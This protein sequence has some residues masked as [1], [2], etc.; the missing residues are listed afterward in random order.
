MSQE[1]TD[2]WAD[3]TCADSPCDNGGDCH[4]LD[5]TDIDQDQ[6]E[7]FICRCPAHCSGIICQVCDNDPSTLIDGTPDQTTSAGCGMHQL[8]L[9][10]YMT[11]SGGDGW[12]NNHIV[13]HNQRAEA[14][15]NVL[16]ATVPRQSDSSV[17]SFCYTRS[18]CY[19]VTAGGGR[20][21]DEISWEIKFPNGTSLLHGGAPF[22]GQIGECVCDEV[23]MTVEM[24]DIGPQAGDGWNDNKLSISAR[25]QSSSTDR[26]W[27]FEL[28]ANDL[29]IIAGVAVNTK[30]EDVC[31]PPSPCYVVR[32]G[33][34][35]FQSEV[36]WRIVR[37]DSRQP[38]AQGPAGQGA[39]IETAWGQDCIHGCTDPAAINYDHRAHV[40]TSDQPCNYVE[41]CTDRAAYNFNPAAVRDD[42]NCE[43]TLTGIKAHLSFSGSIA[44]ALFNGGQFRQQDVR[45]SN[46]DWQAQGATNIAS[47]DGFILQGDHTQPTYSGNFV[48]ENNGVLGIR[49]VE[50]SQQGSG[51]ILINGEA[52]AK[53]HWSI[54][55]SNHSPRSVAGRPHVAGSVIYANGGAVE[56]V[57]SHFSGNSASDVT[58]TYGGVLYAEHS[59]TVV[60]DRCEFVHN[61]ASHGG[62]IYTEGGELTIRHTSF[63]SHIALTGGVLESMNSVVEI[64]A[65][66][67]ARNRADREDDDRLEA[68]TGGALRLIH[69][70]ANITDVEFDENFATDAG[71]ALYTEAGEI[72]LQH[73]A[74]HHNGRPDA[75]AETLGGAIYSQDGQFQVLNCEF[76]DNDSKDHVSGDAMHM[77]NLDSWLLRDNSFPGS[78]PSDPFLVYT[79]GCPGTSCADN[80]CQPG[81]QCLYDGRSTS[82]SPCPSIQVTETL[83][84]DTI[85]EDGIYCMACPA[86]KQPRSDNQGCEN[87]A[88]T[89]Y[90]TGGVCLTCPAGTQ[91]SANQTHCALCPAGT[92]SAGSSNQLCAACQRGEEPASFIGT[93]A[94]VAEG[95]PGATACADCAAGKFSSAGNHCESCPIGYGA[96]NLGTACERC[97]D[98]TS[99]MPGSDG[100]NAGCGTCPAGTQPSISGNECEMCS[101]GQISSGVGENCRHCQPGHQPND[102]QTDC[103]NCGSVLL[104]SFSADGTLCRQC[105]I[106][107][108]ALG[109]AR[110]DDEAA[111]LEEHSYVLAPGDTCGHDDAGTIRIDTSNECETAARH[112]GLIDI[113]PTVVRRPPAPGSTATEASSHADCAIGCPFERAPHGCFLNEGA[114]VGPI[115]ANTLYFNPFGI[116]PSQ[117]IQSARALCSE[118][119]VPCPAGK[120]SLGGVCVQCTGNTYAPS[121]ARDC[122]DCP[123]NS[124]PV[125]DHSHCTCQIGHYNLSYGLIVCVEQSWTTDSVV[126]SPEYAGMR[127]DWA[128]DVKCTACPPCIQCDA[129]DELPVPSKSIQ[130][131]LASTTPKEALIELLI[132]RHQNS[133]TE[134]VS[135]AKLDRLRNSLSL[136]PISTGDEEVGLKERAESFWVGTQTQNGYQLVGDS[137]GQQQFFD[138]TSFGIGNGG[139]QDQVR[140][141]VRCPISDA[142]LPTVIGADIPAIHCTGGF[143]GPLCNL[144]DTYYTRLTGDGKCIPCAQNVAERTL[145]HEE[146]ERDFSTGWYVPLVVTFVLILAAGAASYFFIIPRLGALHIIN[147]RYPRLLGL[148]TDLKTAIGLTQLLC[149]LPLVLGLDYPIPFGRT[150]N[151]YGLLFLDFRKFAKDNCDGAAMSSDSS[152][153]PTTVYR[154]FYADFIYYVCAQPLVMLFLVGGLWLYGDSVVKKTA[155]GNEAAKRQ[156]ALERRTR[157]RIFLA[158]F[159]VYPQFCSTCAAALSCRTLSS[160]VSLLSRDYGVDC[161]GEYYGLIF[162]VSVVLLALVGLGVP[163]YMIVVVA[164]VRKQRQKDGPAPADRII[165]EGDPYD[166]LI[167]D[168]KPQFIFF[169]AMDCFRKLS[170]ALLGA[171]WRGTDLQVYLVALTSFVFLMLYVSTQPFYLTKSNYIKAAAEAQFFMVVL[172]SVVLHSKGTENWDMMTRSEFG[173]FMAIGTTIITPLALIAANRRCV[174]QQS[175]KLRPTRD[176]TC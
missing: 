94:D 74:F 70:T 98:G 96:N 11:D 62:A 109:W 27:E 134:I 77:T 32:V 30:S 92:F 55:I 45:D 81:E 36:D 108:T 75:D 107:R 8:P 157:S 123:G 121:G 141:V 120:V 61:F 174:T 155:N 146:G 47:N 41:G 138:E 149:M 39:P 111:A 143:R 20:H 59:T 167:E 135:Q 23:A 139:M 29:E 102:D 104:G 14:G 156:R 38:V 166:C 161:H 103:L 137:V 7:A 6:T 159:L 28:T 54:F 19:D 31:L 43:Y 88:P 15:V 46:V 80:P 145:L 65:G 1:Q 125:N 114:T 132:A 76:V 101:V 18:Q 72:S 140:Q 71:G 67:F 44:A 154:G 66:A 133:Q 78:D 100:S 116:S 82:C 34:G 165:K 95:R 51:I 5:P 73:C 58:A 40:T 99:T 148:K 16:S 87:C 56:I 57:G 9:F 91:P 17:G 84:I 168:F 22:R 105:P 144:C 118:P 52:V 83:E 164:A 33:G 152:A 147:K 175:L 64:Y 21:W 136:L 37:T 89:Q 12:S 97:V 110:G 50:I 3:V 173:W 85:S 130:K 170:L 158:T 128:A 129:H 176:H 171:A 127:T 10:V 172:S 49:W 4:I 60:L 126:T 115:Q 48:V 142:C 68:G 25:D 150:L 151:A 42:G 122:V 112:L 162:V 53:I 26:M 63:V 119:C 106:G 169:E 113:V 24:R 93:E 69:V 86:G 124:I 2:Q 131:A 117:G 153:A 79:S 13:V 163:A 35:R 160:Q 90:S